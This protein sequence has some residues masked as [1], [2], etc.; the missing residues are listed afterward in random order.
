M[1]NPISAI[2]GLENFVSAQVLVRLHGKPVGY[3]RAPITNG[4]VSTNTLRELIIAE[5]SA[6]IIQYLLQNG[7][8]SPVKKKELRLEDLFDVEPPAPVEELPLVT[9]VVCT[10]DRTSD[11]TICLDALCQLEYPYLELLVID[12][13]PGTD[14]TKQL[15]EAEYP[16][17]RYFNEPRPGLNWARNRAII[18]A[19]G[20]IIAYTDD[21]V[22]V[23]AGWVKALAALFTQDPEVM[24]VTGLVVPFELETEAQALFER[25]G[26]FGK[27]FERKWHRVN[28]KK[29][30]WGL[31]GTGQFGTGANMAYRRCVFDS[32]GYFDPALDV[33][34]VTNGGGDLEMF[35]R[36]L[37]EGYTLV[38]EPS[39][40]VRHRHRRDYTQLRH[41]ITNNSK[42]LVAYFMRSSRAYP[43]QKLSFLKIWLW[44]LRYWI[45]GR[46]AGNY[47]RS[48]GL[49]YDLHMAELPGCFTFNLYTKSRKHAIETA[50]KFGDATDINI[51]HP[52]LQGQ[53]NISTVEKKHG[54]AIRLIDLSQPLQPLTDVINYARI[55]VFLNWNN[56]ALGHLDIANHYWPVGTI[57]LIELIV[58]AL[59]LKL[60]EP[61]IKLNETSRWSTAISTLRNYYCLSDN[62]QH[63][64]EKPP[65]EVSVSV[66]VA[67]YDRPDDLFQCLQSLVNQQLFR[68]VE[69]IVVDNHPASGLT[70]PV[71]T[72][73]PDVMLVNEA[74]KGLSYAR[75]AGI[76]ASRGEIILSTDDDVIVPT[77]WVEN[78][79]A[80]FS[81]PDVMIVTG[82]VLPFELETT[83]QQFFEMYGGLGRGY[84]HMEIDCKWFES[85]RRRAVPTW[86][87]GACANAAF[88]ASIFGHKKIGMIDET[89]GAGMPTG[90]SEDTYVFYKVLK[91]GYT[92][93]Y[94]PNAY[95]WH[96][97]RKD[98]KSFRW[99]LYNYSKGH[100]AYHLKTWLNDKD[101]RGWVRLF[102]ELPKI[103]F[104]R[105]VKRAMRRSDYP[106]SLVLIEIA[107]NM[108]G[109]WALYKSW[110]RVKSQGHSAPYRDLTR[111]Y[112]NQVL[113][114]SI[115][116]EDQVV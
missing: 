45:V 67:T 13:A 87:L 33:G 35:F 1:S 59:D 96:K 108:A 104:H 8:A 47:F 100:V 42:G 81:R 77:N 111:E 5:H 43:E 25:Y 60:L 53:D 109:P 28:A 103:H 57:R 68:K 74:R 49:P 85:F 21:D 18:E 19:H 62:E 32:I 52:T 22:I 41:Q 79:V 115:D 36:V 107:G 80:P 39:A 31:I 71:V 110:L 55:R 76:N 7:L 30:P 61:S 66:V 16:Q 93:V 14:A 12:N 10:R 116:K 99:Q 73:F 20:E 24:A 89:L 54:T 69:I 114:L 78:L 70:P 4:F 40:I 27:G 23:D 17:V 97:H 9:V 29:V 56:I 11:L 37:K 102:I 91:L 46:L 86:N 2:T 72:Q 105:I 64:V 88:R 58:K 3:I 38:Y 90:C 63:L 44:Y 112:T 113:N 84:K 34:T 92:L 101:W 83:S 48:S 98:M 95:V 15:I 65:A 50:E 106:I 26:G 51:D 75:N 82:N 94:E 6:K